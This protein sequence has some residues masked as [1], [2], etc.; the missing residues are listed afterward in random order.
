MIASALFAA[1]SG[2]MVQLR[3]SGPTLTSAALSKVHAAP[4][5][6]IDPHGSDS[7]IDIDIESPRSADAPQMPGLGIPRSDSEFSLGLNRSLSVAD[8]MGQ[9]G[10]CDTGH[11]AIFV[12]RIALYSSMLVCAARYVLAG[13]SSRAG[14]G[15]H[16][17]S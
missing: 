2:A 1:T 5:P 4:D 13:G 6:P 7:D 16:S 9:L 11:T 8:T 3:N 17:P 14:S 10:L 12:A 15:K